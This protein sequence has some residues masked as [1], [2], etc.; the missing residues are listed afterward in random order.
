MAGKPPPRSDWP[1]VVAVYLGGGALGVVLL[2]LLFSA[3]E[4]LQVREVARQAAE[5]ARLLEQLPSAVID[6]AQREAPSANL[7]R[8][9]AFPSRPLRDAR[10]GAFPQGIGRELRHRHDL[11]RALLQEP[12]PGLSGRNVY[13]LELRPLDPPRGSP[14]YW[15]RLRTPLPLPTLLRPLAALLALLLGILASLLL[16]LRQRYLN[17]I[18][19][20]TRTLPTHSRSHLD[21]LP[22]SGLP[23]VRTLSRRINTLVQQINENDRYQSELLEALVHDLRGPLSRQL[24][25]LEEMEDLATAPQLRENVE[26]LARDTRTLVAITDRLA[27]LAGAFEPMPEREVLAL[28]ELCHRIGDSYASRSVE[29]DVPRLWMR[30]RRETFERSLINL[31]DNGFEHGRPPVRVSAACR[32]ADGVLLIDVDDHGDGLGNHS[33]LHRPR[34]P[35]AADRQRRRH[36]GLGLAIVERFCIDHGGELALLPSPLGG[37]RAELRLPLACWV[38]P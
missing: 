9:D 32:P 22:E 35:P 37:L 10:L 34:I 28:D 8:S 20:I 26:A 18:Q 13:W 21:P 2:L 30:L 36:F 29:I 23:P 14:G 15:L 12:Q 6:A 31:I 25:R 38:R 1:D 5:E 19:R 33:V 11:D 24:L 3:L 7:R 17:P 16:L 27:A 4:R